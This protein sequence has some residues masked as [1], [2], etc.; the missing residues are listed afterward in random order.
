[1]VYNGGMRSP[2]TLERPAALFAVSVAIACGACGESSAERE[3]AAVRER[4][5]ALA[6][7]PELA[8][9]LGRAIFDQAEQHAPGWVKHER[10]YRGT[11]AERGRQSYLAVLPSGHCYRVLGAGGPSVRDLDLAMFDSNNVEIA[12]DV[13]ADR[14]PALGVGASICPADASSYRIEV[15]MRRG[16]GD[17]AF[18]IFRTIE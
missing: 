2:S 17:F 12:R 3:A 13:T 10:L 8:D 6:K 7:D 1:M 18:G 4:V 16:D 14:A 11:L 5:T 9:P 15:R